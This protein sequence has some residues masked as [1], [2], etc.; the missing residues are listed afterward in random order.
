MRLNNCSYIKCSQPPLLPSLL[1]KSRISQRND[2][3]F[4]II[5]G[6]IHGIRL[7]PP[8]F[9]SIILTVG[10]G[11]LPLCC[12]GGLRLRQGGH[13]VSHGVMGCCNKRIERRGVGWCGIFHG[14]YC[15]ST[16]PLLSSC[17]RRDM[18]GRGR[19]GNAG[20]ALSKAGRM[21]SADATAGA[22]TTM[23]P[24]LPWRL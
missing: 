5:F 17:P 13:Q 8:L 16:P 23:S 11:V 24:W 6:I 14:G 4:V 7:A 22:T 20:G 15:A 9:C 21:A 12:C 18:H 2:I 1:S 10:S 19:I 3:L